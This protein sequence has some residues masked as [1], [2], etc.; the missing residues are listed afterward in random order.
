MTYSHTTTLTETF[1]RTI[2]R[3]VASKVVADLRR[4]HSYYG[5]PSPER[6]E[7]YYEELTELL[8]GDYVQSVEYGF[9]CEDRRVVS[10]FYEVRSDG[11]LTDGRAGG[12]YAR[13][14]IS[15]A[16][17]FSFLIHSPKWWTLTEEQRRQIEKR[18]PFPRGSGASPQDGDGYWVTDRP[19]SWEGI[20]T[21]RR[22]FRP[23]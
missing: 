22:T 8:A 9:K 10:L 2:A 13:A 4:M 18:L 17:W 3:Y 16:T 20:G 15:G 7:D 21:Q 23:Y 5:K 11:T 1:T 6:I 14:N 12:V 19:Y